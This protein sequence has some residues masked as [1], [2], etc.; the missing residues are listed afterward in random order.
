MAGMAKH[1]RR[2]NGD[3]MRR[4]AMWILASGVAAIAAIVSYSHIYDL[5]RAHG[6]TGVPG[7]AAAAVGRHAHPR[8]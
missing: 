1:S 4:G 2:M 5:G 6:G 7:A 8:R 3:Q